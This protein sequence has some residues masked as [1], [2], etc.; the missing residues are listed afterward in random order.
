MLLRQ[1][2][3]FHKTSLPSA[4]L[5]V[6]EPL[7]LHMLP[8]PPAQMA[9]VPKELFPALCQAGSPCSS[10]GCGPGSSWACWVTVSSYPPSVALCSGENAA[11]LHYGHAGAPNDRTIKDGDIW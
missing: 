5:Q 1:P 9:A 3:P 7:S 2:G 11:V 4:P 6:H 10:T 8:A